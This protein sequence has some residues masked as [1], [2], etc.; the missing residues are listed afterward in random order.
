[1]VRTNF[2]INFSQ[3]ESAFSYTQNLQ[4]NCIKAEFADLHK[5]SISLG[6]LVVVFDFQGD[7][8]FCVHSSQLHVRRVGHVEIAVEIHRTDTCNKPAHFSVK[9]ENKI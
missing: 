3:H 8:L 5:R 6:Q 2:F 1:M 7:G 4:C 9:R